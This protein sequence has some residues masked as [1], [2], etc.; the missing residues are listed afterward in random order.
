[1]PWI[2]PFDILDPLLIHLSQY[3]APLQTMDEIENRFHKISD[4]HSLEIAFSATAGTLKD[5][6]DGLIKSKELAASVIDNSPINVYNIEVED[7]NK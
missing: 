2:F 5:I 4:I 3:S 6:E 1:M 7:H